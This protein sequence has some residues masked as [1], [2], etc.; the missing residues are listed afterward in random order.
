MASE[1][2]VAH[3]SDIPVGTH[4]VFSIAGREI[5]VFNV[6]GEYYALPSNCHHQNGPLCR[7]TVSGTV[8]SS[9]ESGW[10]PVWHR[11][12]EILICPWHSMEFDILTGK[13]LSEPQRR[14]PTYKV[15]TVDC[16][17]VVILP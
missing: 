10:R 6:S 13:C 17:I 5:G 16:N 1:H 14:I 4:K 11:D 3:V 8:E 15:A 2:V 7:G 9:A 12:G